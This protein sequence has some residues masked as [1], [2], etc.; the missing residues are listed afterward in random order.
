MLN[1]FALNAKKNTKSKH[2]IFEDKY[3]SL[4]IQSQRFFLE[5]LNYIHYNPCQLKW[6]LVDNPEDFKYSSASNYILGKGIFD[7]DMIDF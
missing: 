5:K 6:K 4:V 3:D 2:K 1:Y 7:V